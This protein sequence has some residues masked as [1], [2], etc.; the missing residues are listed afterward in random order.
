[1]IL[2]F[3]MMILLYF[4]AGSSYQKLIRFF[5]GLVMLLT[6]VTPLLGLFGNGEQLS[7]L[8]HVESY[9]QYLQELSGSSQNFSV[10][11]QYD[12]SYYEKVLEQ[13]FLADA[14]EKEFGIR[15][16]EVS[17]NDAYEPEQVRIF[18]ETAGDGEQ[19]RI[20]LEDVYGLEGQVM[21]E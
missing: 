7:D 1:M 8:I 15:A 3:L 14:R 20:Y 16:V 13:Q 18:E 2:Y 11:E 12:R 19:F 10:G 6:I 17:L 9:Q 4:T 21:V 5:M